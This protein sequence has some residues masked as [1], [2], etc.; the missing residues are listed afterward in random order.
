MTFCWPRWAAPWPSTCRWR[1]GPRVGTG[2]HRR[3]TRT[4]AEQDVAA[5]FGAFLGYYL[6]RNK[7]DPAVGLDEATRRIAAGSRDR[8]KPGNATSTAW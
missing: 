8:S 2:E 5:P 7:P 4:M 3:H 1:E 6:V